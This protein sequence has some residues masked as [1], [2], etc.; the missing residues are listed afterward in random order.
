MSSWPTPRAQA[1][2]HARPRGRPLELADALLT[3]VDAAVDQP[4]LAASMHGTDLLNSYCANMVLRD[5]LAHRMM[6][7]M[8]HCSQSLLV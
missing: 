6:R 3:V 1:L 4:L 7:S 5:M 2:L 8:N